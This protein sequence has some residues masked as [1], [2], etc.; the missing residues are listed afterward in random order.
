MRVIYNDSNLTDSALFRNENNTIC[1]RKTQFA[2]RNLQLQIIIYKFAAV[3]FTIVSWKNL[4]KE[5]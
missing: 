4:K 1:N 3:K 2:V 5:L